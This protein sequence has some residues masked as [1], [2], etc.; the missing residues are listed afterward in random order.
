MNMFDMINRQ[1]MN[2]EM[3]EMQDEGGM[4]P[5]N[6]SGLLKFLKGWG[7]QGNPM[8]ERKM[9]IPRMED[10]IYPYEGEGARGWEGGSSGTN[11][12]NEQLP[13]PGDF[14]EGY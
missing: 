6:L 9:N 10:E 13:N 12:Y 4:S 7:I 8:P 14:S 11:S 1:G 2:P 5:N 3:G